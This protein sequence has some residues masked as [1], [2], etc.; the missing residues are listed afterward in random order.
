MRKQIAGVAMFAA[1]VTGCGKKDES[2]D[3]KPAAERPHQAGEE[4][5]QEA[6]LAKLRAAHPP[7]EAAPEPEPEPLPKHPPPPKPEP[8]AAEPPATGTPDLATWKVRVIRDFG[9]EL[10]NVARIGRDFVIVGEHGAIYASATGQYDWRPMLATT[11]EPLWAIAKTP[12]G[13]WGV[14]GRQGYHATSTDGTSW[15]VDLVDMK[16]QALLALGSNLVA[17]GRGKTWTTSDGAAWEAHDVEALEADVATVANG[18]GVVMS[19][20]A[21]EKMTSIQTSKDG[22][23]WEMILVEGELVPQ[24]V[25]F[26]RGRYWVVTT[27]PRGLFSSTDLTQWEEHKLPG[28]EQPM[29]VAAS[30]DAVVVVGRNGYI[31]AGA[32]P[33]KL[34]LVAPVTA[35]TLNDVACSAEACTAVG[36]R[37][38]IVSTETVP[39]NP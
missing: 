25:A 15:Q 22:I 29:A 20:R 12:K 5:E 36:A 31:A 2:P 13:L 17:V 38:R 3:V 16:A 11:E 6:E 37:G 18:L 23:T 32:E 35:E 4:A 9:Y 30:D 10:S 21:A 8:E 34:A 28:R 14:V 19:Y 1:L 39:R 24:D 26:G 27:N 33:D 7:V